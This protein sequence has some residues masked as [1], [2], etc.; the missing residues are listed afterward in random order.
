MASA[1]APSTPNLS[2]PTN[3]AIQEPITLT[4]SW[5]SVTGATSYKWYFQRSTSLLAEDADFFSTT[6]LSASPSRTGSGGCDS[7]Q[8][9]YWHVKAFV[10]NDSSMWSSIW[11]FA[12]VPFFSMPSVPVLISPTNNSSGVPIYASLQWNTSTSATSYEAEISSTMSFSNTIYDQ[13]SVS[14][15]LNNSSPLNTATSYYWRARAS[16]LDSTSNWSSA[17]S[18]VTA[19]PPKLPLLSSPS[20]GANIQSLSITFS[21]QSSNEPTEW[22]ENLWDSTNSPNS[23]SLIWGFMISSKSDTTFTASPNKTYR[24]QVYGIEAG[25]NSGWSSIWSFT[26]FVTPTAPTLISPSNG[27]GTQPTSLSM[28]W[29]SISGAS[30]YTIQVS[31]S[32][33]FTATVSTQTGLTG[34]TAMINSLAKSATYYWKVNASN[35][36]GTS[37]W[38]SVWSFNTSSTAVLPEKAV[39]LSKGIAISNLCISYD[40]PSASRISVVLYDMQGKQVRQFINGLQNAGSY[41]INF[42]NAKVM[43][44]Y[45]IVQF[46]AGNYVVQK[47]LVLVN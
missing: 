19:L 23:D 2:S 37:S 21:W 45:Y 30:T 14:I 29:S 10:A 17:W 9:Y 6:L 12:T 18:F 39:Y 8:T 34:V 25:G 27:S 31:T 36:G 38:S 43:A 3:G 42:G 7:G 41:R 44:G 47:R 40:L 26:T 13:Q 1:A 16:S 46:K 11:S 28:S 35:I 4:L 15:Y 20:N 22:E 24:W 32:S 5:Q 33:V